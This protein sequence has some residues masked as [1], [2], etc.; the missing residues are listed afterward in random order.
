[1]S[2]EPPSGLPLAEGAEPDWPA[3]PGLTLAYNRM[4]SFD[5]DLVREYMHLD[6]GAL[7][8]FDLRPDEHDGSMEV[9]SRLPPEELERLD[10]LIRRALD[11]G[12]SVYGAY[13]WIRCRDGSRRWLHTQG[14]VLRDSEGNLRRA[15]GIVRDATRELDDAAKR[16]ELV[17][18]R[19][20]LTGMVRR[21]TALLARATTVQDVT[22]ALKDA[23]ALSNLGAVS[24][25][26]GIVENGHVHTVTEGRLG[27]YVPELRYTRIDA[28]FP[29]SE[30]V[31]T[32]RPRY[33]T[34]REEFR[35]SFPPLW[36]H[37]RHLPVASGAYL[38]LIVQGRTIGALGMLYS[39]H[40]GFTGEERNLLVTL[41]S[42]IAQ[43]LQRAMLFEQE[44][45]LADSLQRAMLPHRIP[46]VPGARIAVR[47]RA[48]RAGRDI[49]GDWYDVVPLSDGR[50][51]LMI[52]DVQG[53]DTDAAAV[54]GQL[55]IVLWAYVSEGHSPAT[56]MARAS[57]FL[58]ELDT[59]RFATCTYVEADLSTGALQIVRAGHLEPMVRDAD[60][61][62]VT[63][64]TEGG[65]PLGITNTSRRR[66]G[67]DYPVTLTT[68]APGETLLIF[69]DGLVERPG[70]TLDEGLERLARAVQG[71]PAD[72][73]QLADRLG[74]M[75]GEHGGGGDDMA[76]L[77]MRRDPAPRDN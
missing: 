9:P 70:A 2:G 12:G 8:V 45:D 18:T 48:A 34:S 40:G 69:T 33:I 46:E 14:H 42:S 4:G 61:R 44:H 49:G 10:T 55:R 39:R 56:A 37:I 51:G 19:R 21:V 25:M 71:G 74:E 43:S 60:G 17:E 32:L 5:I 16:T 73:Q 72:I 27:L 68:L 57:T 35:R 26:L 23:E 3:G 50:V 47:Y 28:R 77:L 66:G 30:V 13:F 15:I 1:M 63:I 6:P 62:C 65:L 52:G 59:D 20:R 31:R 36:H 11:K 64:D 29:M 76:L 54:M 7:E 24:V 22:D 75:V 53:H 58:H 41:S 38:P 67:A